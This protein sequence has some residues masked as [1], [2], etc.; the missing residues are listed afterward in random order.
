[1]GCHGGYYTCTVRGME[2][3]V[4]GCGCDCGCEYGGWAMHG[5][6]VVVFD[7]WLGRSGS[8][9]AVS[10]ECK[11]NGGA[12]LADEISGCLHYESELG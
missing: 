5:V 8:R 12:L 11:G 2:G 3:W 9:E 7:V 4:C 10:V 6:R 1:M